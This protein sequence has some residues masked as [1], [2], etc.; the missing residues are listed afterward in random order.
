[1][2]CPKLLWQSSSGVSFTVGFVVM[3]ALIEIAFHAGEQLHHEL[4][5]HFSAAESTSNTSALLTVIR[6][7]RTNT[8]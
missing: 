7:G 4:T 3:L 5:L 2:A 8:F 1:M 6:I